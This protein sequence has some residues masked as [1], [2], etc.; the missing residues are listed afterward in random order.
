MRVPMSADSGVS[1]GNAVRQD[2]LSSIAATMK[3]CW[4]I[5]WPG[6]L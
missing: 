4:L 2:W 5:G 3:P 6:I 1:S